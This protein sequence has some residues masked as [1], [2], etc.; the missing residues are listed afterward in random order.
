MVCIAP[1]PIPNYM[2]AYMEFWNQYMEAQNRWLEM[3]L[4]LVTLKSYYDD[5]E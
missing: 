4:E 3:Y 2:L 1:A 5:Q